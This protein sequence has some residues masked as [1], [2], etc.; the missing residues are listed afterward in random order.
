MREVGVGG[1]GYHELF[2]SLPA[3]RHLVLVPARNL[4][5][6]VSFKV[7]TMVTVGERTKTVLVT[8]AEKEFDDIWMLAIRQNFTFH[9]SVLGFVFLY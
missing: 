4:N 9:Y 1:N 7:D 2:L 6:V 8:K 3:D 5:S